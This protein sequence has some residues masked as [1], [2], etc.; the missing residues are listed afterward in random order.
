MLLDVIVQCVSLGNRRLAR[1]CMTSPRHLHV[2]MSIHSFSFHHAFAGS[3]E[4]EPTWRLGHQVSFNPAS[5]Y[6]ILMNRLISRIKPPL[7][8]LLVPMSAG[9]SPWRDDMLRVRLGRLHLADSVCMR[10]CWKLPS[11]L[12]EV[13]TV[14]TI[15]NPDVLDSTPRHQDI[16]STCSLGL[17]DISLQTLSIAAI[18]ASRSISSINCNSTTR[19]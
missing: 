1:Y 8:C 2:S 10:D 13:G 7:L 15:F 17:H 16:L 9:I 18:G 3:K 14:H 4:S 12:N 5:W 19:Q 6:K 11:L